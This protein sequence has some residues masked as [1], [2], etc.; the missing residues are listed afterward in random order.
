MIS[1]SGPALIKFIAAPVP[2]APQPTSPALIFLPFGAPFR[3]GARA[4]TS[5]SCFLLH[6]VINAPAPAIPSPASADFPMN[7]L[8]S[9]FCIYFLLKHSFY[10]P[11]MLSASQ[12]TLNPTSIQSEYHH[13]LLGICGSVTSHAFVLVKSR[14]ALLTS[15]ASLLNDPPRITCSRPLAGPRGLT[16]S[17]ES[18]L[19]VSGE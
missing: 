17:V 15:L 5:A 10:L 13:T 4:K 7:L 3:I 9:I 12:T 14:D 11:M 6:A 16:A 19:Y 8:L 18:A 1:R 2:L